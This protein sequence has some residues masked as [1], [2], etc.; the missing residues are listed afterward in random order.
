MIED[1]IITR[2]DGCTL[3]KGSLSP[4]V[5]MALVKE[6][7]KGAEFSP[8]VARLAGAGWA[9]GLPE[10]LD[11]LRATLAE[12]APRPWHEGLSQG[13][14]EWL[15]VGK[16]GLSSASL[17]FKATGVRPRVLRDDKEATYHPVDPADLNRCLLL[18]AMAPEIAD[19][20]PRMRE[21]SP[22]WAVLVDHWDEL[23]TLFHEEAG[24]DW[25]K[26]RSAHRTFQRMQALLGH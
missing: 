19:A 9:I 10:D 5:L 2:R 17:F 23:T 16:Q 13:A 8:D 7:P 24:P 11:R 18:I 26:A 20:L 1:V 21:V 25:S 4:D 14:I 6:H 12:Q 15:A 3:V 22:E